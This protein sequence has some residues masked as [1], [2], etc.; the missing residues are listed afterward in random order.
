MGYWQPKNFVG[1]WDGNNHHRDSESYENLIPLDLD[2]IFPL[3]CPIAD[4][5][6]LGRREVFNLLSSDEDYHNLF[7][8]SS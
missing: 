2:Y 5:L 3:M 4:E 7:I 8:S 1:L 6:K